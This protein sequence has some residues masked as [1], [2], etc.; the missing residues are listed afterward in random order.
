MFLE[1][2]RWFANTTLNAGMASVFHKETRFYFRTVRTGVQRDRA[3]S[4]Q[5]SCGTSPLRLF[6]LRSTSFRVTV[7][8][9][10]LNLFLLLSALL[11]LFSLRPRSVMLRT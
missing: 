3:G 1:S 10:L 5:G 9:P 2:D 6:T 8:L 7:L 11:L 4:V